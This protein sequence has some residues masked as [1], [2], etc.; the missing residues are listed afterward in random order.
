M[1]SPGSPR[2]VRTRSA[3][4]L[5]AAVLGQGLSEPGFLWRLTK[6]SK[7]LKVLGFVTRVARTQ[8][9]RAVPYNIL[10]LLNKECVV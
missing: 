10:V 1:G 8:T 7:V 6:P 5:L 9:L 2:E 3:L 4:C